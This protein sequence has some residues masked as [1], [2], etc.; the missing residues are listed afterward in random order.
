VGMRG[1]R[2]PVRADHLDIER[3]PGILNMNRTMTVTV[4]NQEP[5]VVPPAV[6]R[7]A[8]FRRG[9][10]LEVK[11]SGGVI[12]IVPKLSPDE[13]QDERETRDPKIRAAIRKGREEFFA[14]Q[15][16]PIEEFFAARAARARKRAHRR[17]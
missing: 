10:E 7:R 14:G 6:R 13:L 12:T 17:P 1:Q 9:Q 16:R 8:G 2:R 5:L 3:M 15:T 11:A 4:K